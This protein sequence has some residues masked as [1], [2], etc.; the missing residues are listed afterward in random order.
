VNVY[1]TAKGDARSSV[2]VQHERLAGAAE[3]DRMKAFW[4][5]RLAELKRA[6]EG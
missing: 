6:L 5:T 1:F 2:S 4:R 3:A